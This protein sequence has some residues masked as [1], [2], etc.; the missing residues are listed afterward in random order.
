[1]I[2]RKILLH[3][4]KFCKAKFSRV[5]TTKSRR[6]KKYL[7]EKDLSRLI[8]ITAGSCL[9]IGFAVTCLAGINAVLQSK[10]FLDVFVVL[11]DSFGVVDLAFA[12][13]NVVKIW[14]VGRLGGG[15]DGNKPGAG[16][17][18]RR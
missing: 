11:F 7:L 10:I 8:Y 18:S 6:Y 17:W 14:C 9:S 1:M 15:A 4:S 3:P 5:N 2:H 12:V 16:D 13:M